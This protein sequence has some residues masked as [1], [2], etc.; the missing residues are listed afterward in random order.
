MRQDEPAAQPNTAPADESPAAI[1][2]PT[3]PAAAGDQSALDEL[4]GLDALRSRVDVFI[5]WLGGQ[6]L[7]F[8]VAVQGLILLAAL[9]PA[10][11]FGPQ[12][13][14]LI[15]GQVAARAPYGA[16]R[17]AANA[18]ARIATPIALYAI[19][20]AAVLALAQFS[21]STAL[22]EAGLSLL[23]AWI[24]IRLVTLVI[25]S[26]LWSKVAFYVAWPLAALDAFGLL[27]GALRQLDAF[28]VPIGID[29][30]G[31]PIEYSALD[32]LRTVVIFGAL[33][34]IA[35][36]VNRFVKDRL[37]AV[38][39]L[40]AS[41]KALLFKILDVLSPVIALFIALQVVGFPFATLAVFSGAVGLGIGLGLQKTISNFFA[42]FTLVADKSIKPGDVIEIGDTFGWITEMN[43]R[44]VSVRTRDGMEHL[45]P[46]DKFLENGVINW[47]H[48]DRAVRLHA[49]FN[50]AYS[51]RDLRAVKRLAEDTALG[52]DRVLATPAPVCNLTEFG[53]S[54]VMF[55][56]R[57]WISDPASGI[58]NVT[59]AVLLALWD[60]FH[61]RSVEI[62]YPQLD[63][64]IRSAPG[65]EGNLTKP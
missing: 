14:K 23:T 49:G 8:D 20:H 57:F 59:S 44:H 64:H 19:L 4:L 45:I 28:A 43:A 16:L 13:K 26:D 1:D 21:R 42:G 2:A 46:N 36:L 39:E 50:V 11:L 12:L 24:A 37:A 32:L 58:S 7:T 63:V 41:F 56:L 22:V 35:S 47:S 5:D 55:D 40:T 18:F 60:A 54:A 30:K 3:E 61:D 38:E 31:L 9:V 15:I 52:V 33:F 27:G 34:W 65:A 62:P 17:R 25:R 6:M 10:A 51:N 53:E 29:A 48:T